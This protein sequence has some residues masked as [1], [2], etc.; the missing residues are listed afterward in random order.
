ML[1]CTLGSPVARSLASVESEP[2]DLLEEFFELTWE[3][4]NSKWKPQIEVSW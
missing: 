4:P 1:A 3:A 2:K